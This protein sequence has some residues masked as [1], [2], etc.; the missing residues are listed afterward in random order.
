MEFIIDANN[1][2]QLISENKYLI[3]DNK[4]VKDNSLET[5]TKISIKNIANKSLLL[6]IS[7]VKLPKIKIE[8]SNCIFSEVLIRD[9]EIDEV[10]FNTVEVSE[11][12]EGNF[13]LFKTFIDNS[14]LKYLWFHYCKLN[15][16]IIVR[17]ESEIESLSV[18]DTFIDRSFTFINSKSN[19]LTIESSNVTEIVIDRNDFH[20]PNGKTEVDTINIF[21]TE[22]LKYIKIWDVNFK[23]LQIHK[24]ILNKSEKLTD[25]NNEIY[26]KAPDKYKDVESIKIDDSE[27]LSKTIIV[28][29]KIKHLEFFNSSFDEV[30][31]N[32]WKVD[33][34]IFS[35][36]KFSNSIY[37]GRP[38]QIKIINKL[39]IDNC[40]FDHIFNMSSVLF[41]REAF[42]RGL[43]FKKYPSFFYHNLID[44]KCKTDF[45]Y[46]NLQNL[47]FQEIHFRHFSFKEFDIT[48]VE[49]RDCRW[50]SDRNFF[51]DRNLVLDEQMSNNEIEDLIKVRDIYS[52]LRVSAEKSSDFLNLKKFYISEQETKRKIHRLKKD[53]TEF[54]LMSFHKIISSY[55]ENF[56]KPLFFVFCSIILFALFFM[57][58]GF[59]VGNRLV[60]YEFS[61]Q[62]S[63]TFNTLRDFGYS[64]IYSLKNIVPF[65]MGIN[66]Y[67]N[68]DKSL[69]LSQTLELIHKILNVIFATSFTAA[70]IKYLRK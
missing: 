31:L 1:Y 61:F 14:K 20:K 32:Y 19:T 60:K 38:N 2:D 43:V 7:K 40:V 70:F 49:F 41:K 35:N 23:N 27:I 26:I 15:N 33:S 62:A 29:D 59:N 39:L 44:E 46:S 37:F 63:N 42:F 13:A 58:S 67:L 45:Q 25:H 56:K 55:G 64:L 53:R 36:S 28:F 69:E 68:S 57:F 18:Y 3:V 47:V 34:L 9:S 66:F 52:K 12:K 22:G 21:R 24:I 48:N 54:I 4:F 30:T 50:S 51:I 65:Q 5:F 8:I 11:S 6:F 16:G 10:V 17:K